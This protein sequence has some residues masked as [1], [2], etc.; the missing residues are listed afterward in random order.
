LELDSVIILANVADP[1]QDFDALWD[2]EWERHLLMQPLAR[3]KRQAKP[4]Q[5]AIYH[6][7]VRVVF[8]KWRT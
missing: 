7:H 6:L 5:Y 3:V 8:V 1:R 2:A 4:E